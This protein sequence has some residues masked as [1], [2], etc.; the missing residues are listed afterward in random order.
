M[1][2]RLFISLLMLLLPTHA[3]A[4]GEVVCKAI[5]G[6]SGE[7]YLSVGRL[8]VLNIL[9]AEVNAFGKTWSTAQDAEN[10]IVVGQAFEDK[11]QLLVDFTNSNIEEI[12][13]SLRTS[14]MSTPKEYGEA[15]VLRIGEAVYPVLCEGG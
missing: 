8:P 10:Q 3:F 13:I 4:T 2:I 12:I 14:R 11:S 7:V 5:D 9:S 15:G 1:K 6:R